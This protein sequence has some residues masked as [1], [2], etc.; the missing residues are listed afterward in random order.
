MSELKENSVFMILYN[1]SDGDYSTIKIMTNLY[2]AYDY[3]CRQELN[4]IDKQETFKL[5]NVYNPDDVARASISDVLHICYIQ[6]EEYNK[7]HLCDYPN[8]SQYAIVKF[9]VEQR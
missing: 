9:V 3:I 7:F 8:I 2:D 4:Q 5:F 6:S 1:Y